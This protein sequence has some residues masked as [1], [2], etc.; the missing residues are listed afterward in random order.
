MNVLEESK[1]IKDEKIQKE[2]RKIITDTLKNSDE[3]MFFEEETLEIAGYKYIETRLV[4]KNG[5]YY[6]KGIAEGPFCTVCWDENHQL[7]KTKDKRRKK[8]LS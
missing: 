6:T 4:K 8:S 3:E 5:F 7:N 2:L 1:N